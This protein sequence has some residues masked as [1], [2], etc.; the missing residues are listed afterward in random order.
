MPVLKEL[1]TI[2]SVDPTYVNLWAKTS[3][4]YQIQIR[5]NSNK[6]AIEKHTSKHGL[7]I[8]EDKEQKYLTIY[9]P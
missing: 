3:S 8:Q 1:I 9:K 7:T 4:H 5:S 6:E 2:D